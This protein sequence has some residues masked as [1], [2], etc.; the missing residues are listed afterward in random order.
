MCLVVVA[1]LSLADF[2]IGPS[3]RKWIK[4]RIAYLWILLQDN[5]TTEI[6][7][8]SA[9]L[10]SNLL[11]KMF[12]CNYKGVHFYYRVLLFSLLATTFSILYISPLFEFSSSG[13]ASSF[14]NLVELIIGFDVDRVTLQAR[15]NVF[16][17]LFYQSLFYALPIN[18]VFDLASVGLTVYLLDKLAKSKRL[19]SDILILLLDFVIVLACFLSVLVLLVYLFPI[20]NLPHQGSLSFFEKM[21]LIR[22][23]ANSSAILYGVFFSSVAPS[24]LHIFYIVTTMGIKI[25]SPFLR[26]IVELLLYRFQESQTGTLTLLAI[27]IGTIAK[28]V[29]QAVKIYGG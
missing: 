23:Y 25:L 17:S 20:T 26:P 7:A 8:S 10:S 22:I 2:L 28:L 14:E 4:N 29:Q 13:Y 12:V 3:N 19:S 16:T 11:R 1:L 15:P 5:S 9:K 6:L 21:S 24:F 27:S 18:F